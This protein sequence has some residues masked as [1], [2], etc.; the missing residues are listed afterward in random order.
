MT[1][2]AKL[3]IA[4]REAAD[5]GTRAVV[6]EAALRSLERAPHGVR[7]ML[8]E[9]Q[10]NV[11]ADLAPDRLFLLSR[12]LRPLP[13]DTEDPLAAVCLAA[14]LREQAIATSPKRGLLATRRAQAFA[15]VLARLDRFWQVPPEGVAWLFHVEHDWMDQNLYLEL[16]KWCLART[17]I[18]AVIVGLVALLREED[19]NSPPLAR[20]AVMVAPTERDL[21][22]V[23]G[24]EHGLR[25][26]EDAWRV[27]AQRWPV[28]GPQPHDIALLYTPVAVDHAARVHG[29]PAVAALLQR[30]ASAA[31]HHEIRTMLSSWADQVRAAP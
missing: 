1:I 16:E 13:G 22:E 26:G 9:W 27:A 2:E 14:F 18:P 21:I 24:W 12:L 17:Q 29:R 15:L 3:V 5:P 10:E 7:A 4:F 19:D 23:A 8:T 11:L 6:F 28:E 25:R 20:T 31:E 30:A